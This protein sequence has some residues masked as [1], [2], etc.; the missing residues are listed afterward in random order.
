[1]ETVCH[2]WPYIDDILKFVAVVE[3]EILNKLWVQKVA[4]SGPLIS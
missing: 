3:V 2:N 4:W 1:M